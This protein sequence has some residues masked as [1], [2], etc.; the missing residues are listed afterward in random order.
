LINGHSSHQQ[1]G[2]SLR[3]SCTALKHALGDHAG[4]ALIQQHWALVRELL[5]KFPGSE[6]IETAGDSFLLV[7]IKPSQAVTFAL[8]LQHRQRELAETSP[9]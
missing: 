4:M 7:F 3:T 1:K 2:D 9:R 5:S 8:L 6:E